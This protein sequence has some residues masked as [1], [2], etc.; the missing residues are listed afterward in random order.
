MRCGD[1][2]IGRAREQARL[3][4]CPRCSGY[5][6]IEGT[7]PEGYVCH[8]CDGSGAFSAHETQ[9]TDAMDIGR[10]SIIAMLRRDILLAGLE[11]VQAASGDPGPRVEPQPVGRVKP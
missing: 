11:R 6:R 2:V 10:N 1:A 8:V 7:P 4:R 5:G 9:D 3:T